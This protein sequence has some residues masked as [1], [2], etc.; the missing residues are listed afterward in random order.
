MLK[1]FGFLKK[2]PKAMVFVD[3]EYWFYSY[4]TRFGIRPDPA[5]WR[6]SLEEEYRISDIMVFADFSSPGLGDERN[7]LREITNTIIET[8][9]DTQRRKKDMTDFVMLDYIYQ[10]ADSNRRVG[11]YILFTGDGHFQSVVKYLVQKKRKKVTV[12]GVE[13]SFSRRLISSASKT[14]TL[15]FE[16]EVYKNYRRMIIENMAY[17]ASKPNIIPTYTTT[18]EA[19]SKKY[20]VPVEGIKAAISKMSEEGYLERRSRK[21]DF[22]RTVKIIAPVWEKL[23]ADGLWSTE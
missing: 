10:F 5:Q 9:T 19:V 16:D 14:V 4:K 1:I 22:N 11:T 7:K 2:K 12:Y 6:R 13:D 23:I 17:V 8:G 3:Y 18:A 21:V 20:G 15:P